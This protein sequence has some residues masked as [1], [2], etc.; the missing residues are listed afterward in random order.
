MPPH[1]LLDY[2][3]ISA[4]TAPGEFG[5]RVVEAERNGLIDYGQFAAALGITWF[6]INAPGQRIAYVAFPFLLVLLMKPSTLTLAAQARRLLLPFLTWSIV[7]GMLHTALALKTND[8]PFSWWSADMILSGTWSHLWILPFGFFAAVL[9]P[10]FQ[11]PIASLGAAWLAALVFVVK[12]PP[13]AMPFG[14]WAFGIIPV[15][16]GI[17]YYSWGWRLAVVTL[18]GSWMILHFGRPAPDNTTILVGCALALACLTFRLPATQLSEWCARMS[19]WVFLAHPLVIVAGQSL[20][21]TWVELG[22][23]SLVGSVILAQL[24]DMAANTSRRRSLEF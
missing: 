14:L 24:L 19:I 6:G 7:F 18:L 20:R 11:H 1:Y 21:I 22:L 15:L 10:W 2:K 8:P 16:V 3:A 5:E 9:S 12:G 4:H 13:A 23:F 17:A